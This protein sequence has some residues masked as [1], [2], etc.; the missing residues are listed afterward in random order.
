MWD[1]RVI[2]I[3]KSAGEDSRATDVVKQGLALQQ[4]AFDI[5]PSSYLGVHKTKQQIAKK[6]SKRGQVV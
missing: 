1:I 3:H 4:K 6:K 5:S 2:H